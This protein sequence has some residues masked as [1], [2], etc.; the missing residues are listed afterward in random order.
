MKVHQLFAKTVWNYK[1]KLWDSKT[2]TLC[3]WCCH[4]N[5]VH[6]L[7]TESLFRYIND[8][9]FHFLFFNI[10]SYIIDFMFFTRKYPWRNSKINGQ[11]SSNTLIRFK[12]SVKT[13]RVLFRTSL[14]IATISV[15]VILQKI[16]R[17]ATFIEYSCV[18]NKKQL[19]LFPLCGPLGLV[20]RSL[21]KKITTIQVKLRVDNT[22]T[23]HLNA[24]SLET[25]VQREQWL[26]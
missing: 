3:Y 1:V 19:L 20:T 9:V 16:W 10:S 12:Q 25:Y 11:F 2:N 23:C 7:V 8:P 6:S 22:T 17:L 26:V 24:T 21:V 14:C 15:R 5:Y 18:E 4:Q 13:C